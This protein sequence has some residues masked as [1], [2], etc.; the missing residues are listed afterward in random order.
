MHLLLQFADF[1]RITIASSTR[2]L[3]ERLHKKRQKTA[4]RA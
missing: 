4:A 2:A 1:H 3:T